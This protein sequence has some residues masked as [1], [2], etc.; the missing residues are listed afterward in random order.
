MEPDFYD[1]LKDYIRKEKEEVAKAWEEQD[2]QRLVLFANLVKLV[3]DLISIR[4][5]K[6]V[7]LALASMF[8]E[9]WEPDNLVGWEKDLYKDVVETVRRYRDDV[10]VLIGLKE[11]AVEGKAEEKTLK[12]I[13]VKIL[14]AI[15]EFIGTDYRTYGPFAEGEI[16]DLPPDIADILLVRSLAEVVKNEEDP[17]AQI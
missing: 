2:I 14:K 11:G 10:L 5:R 7:S 8:D 17:N 6:I 1:L 3:N 9:A 12:L 16:V 4:Q 13:R 15:P